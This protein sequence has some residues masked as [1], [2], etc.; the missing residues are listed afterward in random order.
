[1]PW[2]HQQKLHRL[3]NLQ[4][5]KLLQQKQV[6]LKQV[7]ALKK[8]VPRLPVARKK[9]RQQLEKKPIKFFEINC[10]PFFSIR[11]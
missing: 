2:Q 10:S 8:Q 6:N 3:E 4:G 11:A 7:V 9:Q 1:M 5:R